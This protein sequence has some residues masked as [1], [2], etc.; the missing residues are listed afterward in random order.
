MS[1]ATFTKGEVESGQNILITGIGGGVA[2]QALQFAVAAGANVFVTSGKADKIERAK[3][4]GA[5]AGVNYKDADWAKQLQVLLPKDRPYLDAVIDSAGGNITTQ[6][7]RLLKHGARVSV[8]GQTTGKPHTLG[9]GEILKNVEL[10]GSTMGSFAEFEAAVAFVDKHK[11]VPVV[12]QV[13]AGL[14]QAEHAI[15]VIKDG[16]QFGKIVISIHSPSSSKL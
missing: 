1:R 13:F 14:D 8:Y 10:R 9:M 7:L 3:K 12:H 5:A 15:Q 4:L 6:L 11:I 16:E 2:I